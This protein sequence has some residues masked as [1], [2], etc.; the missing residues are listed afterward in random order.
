VATNTKLNPLETG[1][2][3][4]LKRYYDS[5]GI[6]GVW[7][8]IR[9][10]RLCK[11]LEL[12]ELELGTMFCIPHS[13]M[14]RWLKKDRFPAYVALHFALLENWVACERISKQDPTIK[15]P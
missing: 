6:P 7:D 2:S 4:R 9:V 8:A 14:K 12:S 10:R 3:V 1:G 13:A 5:L 11:L 15:F